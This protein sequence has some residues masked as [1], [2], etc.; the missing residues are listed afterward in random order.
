MKTVFIGDIHGR[1]NWKLIVHQEQ[2]DRVVFV[3]DYFDTHDDISAALQIH[4]FKEIIDYKKS[5]TAEVIMLIGNHDHHYFPEIGYTGTSGYQDRSAVAISHELMQ[6][7]DMLQMAY[8]VPEPFISKGGVDFIICSHAGISEKWLANQG[9]PQHQ[10]DDPVDFVNDVWK[11]RPRAFEFT[12]SRVSDSSGDS[13]GQT[14]IWIRP[15]YLLK[16][17][18]DFKKE[19]I[20]IVGHTQ[21]SKIDIE[22]KATGGRYYFIDTLGTSGEY[23]VLEDGKFSAKK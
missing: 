12:P 7:R 23:L 20:Q 4:N 2:P 13:S 18:P 8:R 17:C 9:W 15:S 22:G 19:Y 3:G 21:Q 14:P 1:S 11:H 6:H 5:T 16:D 10:Y